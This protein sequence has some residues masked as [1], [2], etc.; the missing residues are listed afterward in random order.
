M[1]VEWPI[2]LDPPEKRVSYGQNAEDVRLWRAFQG[3]E[4]GFYVEVGAWDP[5]IDSISR[6]F[7][8]RGWSGLVVEPVAEYAE[9]YRRL[10]PRDTTIQVLAGER[11]DQRAFKVIPGTGLSTMAYEDMSMHENSGFAIDE[12]H[13]PVLPLTDILVQH[14]VKIIHF[15]VID[16]EG[17]EREVISGLDLAK[18]RPWILVIESIA[19]LTNLPAHANWEPLLLAAQYEFAAFDGVNRFYVA[20]ERRELVERISTPPNA[21]DSYKTRVEW[22]QS[23]EIERLQNVVASLLSS[24]SWR[25]TRFLRALSGRH[26]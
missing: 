1:D 16:V 22:A 4:E 24:R 18:F 25:F 15:M 11:S 8:G 19:P 13:V 12:R 26:Q 17:A 10:R 7:Y 3:L 14:A 6:S 21:V 5:E 20:E 2:G 23:Q 9:R